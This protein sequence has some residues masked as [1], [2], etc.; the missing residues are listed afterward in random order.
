MTTDN[1]GTSERERTKRDGRNAARTPN[2]TLDRKRTVHIFSY[3]T[4]P[5]A[6]KE[7]NDRLGKCKTKRDGT[8]KRASK[9]VDISL[10]EHP[11]NASR[12][13]ISEMREFL[14]DG[15]DTTLGAG[16]DMSLSHICDRRPN[17]TGIR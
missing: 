16:S 7:R 10:H 5:P 6:R 3:T 14:N 9:R 12:W 1:S 4:A 11:E 13:C 17:L 2:R 8:H 15:R